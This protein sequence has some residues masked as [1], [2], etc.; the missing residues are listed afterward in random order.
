MTVKAGEAVSASVVNSSFVSRNEDTDTVGKIDLLNA[1]SDNVTDVQATINDMQTATSDHIIDTEDAHDATAISYDSSGNSLTAS[2]VQTAIDQ[3]EQASGGG[4]ITNWTTYSPTFVASS[5]ATAVIGN[6]S[7]NGFY[8]RIG[9]SIELRLEFKVGS[10][11]VMGSGFWLFGLPPGL[12]ADV[13]KIPTLVPLGTAFLGN[14]SG[15]NTLNEMC[16]ANTT[17]DNTAIALVATNFNTVGPIVPFT[18]GITDV[19]SVT[20][21][22]PIT[23]YT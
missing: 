12:T 8:R 23:Q 4:I 19:F 10:T 6:G 11:T 9:D 13:S 22:I 1:D 3:L 21:T 17:Y 14:I 15:G 16:T 7:L 5:G 18:W 20:I 2:D